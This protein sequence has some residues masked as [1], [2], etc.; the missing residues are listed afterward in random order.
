MSG[1]MIFAIIL[2]T[3]LLALTAQRIYQS[4]KRTA[5]PDEVTI[6]EDGSGRKYYREGKFF[7]VPF[8]QKEYKL[9]LAPFPVDRMARNIRNREGNIFDIHVVM[10]VRID[11]SPNGLEL[12]AGRFMNKDTDQI[13]DFVEEIIKRNVTIYL[14]E[15]DIRSLVN[16]IEPFCKNVEESMKEDLL[17]MGILVN[18][19]SITSLEDSQGLMKR[20]AEQKR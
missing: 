6:V 14:Q 7:V 18:S 8:F 1:P 13:S 4:C 17:K 11:D 3:L 12:A 10:E 5:K 19:F 20:L 2:T 15:L 9:S 16:N